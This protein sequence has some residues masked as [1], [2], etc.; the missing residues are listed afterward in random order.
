MAK[1]IVKRMLSLLAL[2]VTAIILL[3][4]CVRFPDPNELNAQKE[5]PYIYPYKNENQNVQAEITIVTDGSADLDNIT[6]EIPHLKYNKSWLFLLTQDDCRQDAYSNTWAAINGKPLSREY[7]YDADHLE[8]GDLPPDVYY[9]GKTLGS[10]DG[11][12]N[13]VR[14]AFTTTLAPEWDWMNVEP[15]VQKG[16]SSNYYR[17]MMKLG[18]VWDNVAEL[19]NYGN[20]I[21]FHNVN[22]T[23]A[24]NVD[25]IVK[26]YVISQGIVL[27]K[28]QGRGCKMLSEPD[29]NK[30][31]INAAYSYGPIQIMTAQ[32][33]TEILYPFKVTENIEG[34]VLNRVFYPVEQVE[35]EVQKLLGKK[36]EERSA[37]HMGVYR[38]AYDMANVLLWL[39]DIH[40][41]DGSDSV[42]MP[43]LEEYYEYNYYRIHGSVK[44]K[45]IYNSITL[46][47]DLPS[48]T[49][50][51]FP[52][53][54]VNVK[55]LKKENIVSITPNSKITGFSY[56]NYDKGVMLNIDCRKYLPEHATH[57]VEKYE[58]DRSES[59]RKDALYFVN[60][61]KDSQGKQELLNRINQ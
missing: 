16:E 56:A 4:S 27:E 11:A 48:G 39:N 32:K 51:Y 57:Y 47:V 13:E 7:F 55:G 30:T 23:N 19:L 50:F 34:K 53:V 25:S 29:G 17:F 8:A 38:S 59:N 14:F 24:N 61:L 2:T 18:L 52:A 15:S 33:E 10:T 5:P 49:Y 54:T 41:K 26:H 28:L 42:W 12:G 36:K 37:F 22:T 1:K 20:G 40:G 31:Y 44:K 3:L 35:G 60:M 43:S 45:V 46:T 58:K 9:L 21:A 6:T